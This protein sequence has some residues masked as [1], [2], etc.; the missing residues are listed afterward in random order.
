MRT[1]IVLDDELVEEAMKAT[2]ARSP[3]HLGRL[4]AGF[5]GQPLLPAT[6][7]THPR[8]GELYARC[9]WQGVTVRSPHDCPIAALAVEHDLPLLHDDRDFGRIAR[10]EPRLWLSVG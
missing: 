10:I 6:V 1:N 3:W 7:D 4:R 8:A 5:S 9:R 2:G